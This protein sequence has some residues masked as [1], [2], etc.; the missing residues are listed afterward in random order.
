MVRFIELPAVSTFKFEK[1]LTSVPNEYG[2][3]NIVRAGVGYWTG[4]FT[5]AP[6]PNGAGDILG[7]LAE[8][9]RT[10]GIF[11]LDITTKNKVT[12]QPKWI[13]G[14]DLGSDELYIELENTD[15]RTTITASGYA[16]PRVQDLNVGDIISIRNANSPDYITARVVISKNEVSGSLKF[17]LNHRMP[18]DFF[19]QDSNQS[20]IDAMAQFCFNRPHIT[21]KY[22]E[23]PISFTTTARGG[24]T[25]SPITWVEATGD[26]IVKWREDHDPDY[27]VTNNGDNLIASSGNR[28]IV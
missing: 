6:K 19:A 3:I 26:N 25:V 10:G 20:K 24:M 18:I 15:K 11:L 7:N 22:T 9:N 28:L 21:A 2:N 13:S 5:P 4:E 14:F 1:P 23:T 8:G 16:K 12:E 17:E 27:L